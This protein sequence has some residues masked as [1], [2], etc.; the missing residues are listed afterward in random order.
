MM[1]LFKRVLKD[2][3]RGAVNEMQNSG[4]CRIYT[5]T[6]DAFTG[7]FVAYPLLHQYETMFLKL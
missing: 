2:A 7:K 6:Y 1:G 4:F 3:V 5:R